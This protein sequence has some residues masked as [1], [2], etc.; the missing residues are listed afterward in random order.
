MAD[1]CNV[2]A[3]LLIRQALRWRSRQN[4]IASD[5]IASDWIA[6]DWIASDWIAS[7]WI[8]KIKPSTF[9]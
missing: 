7:D 3:T 6:S 5:W 2:P 9:F 8:A 4:W 1:S